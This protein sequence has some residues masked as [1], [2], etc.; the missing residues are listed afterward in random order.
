V[1]ALAALLTAGSGLSA[2]AAEKID[3]RYLLD[4]AV[5]VAAVGP[6]AVLTQPSL[7]M[8][9]VEV[10][11]AVGKKELGIDPLDVEQVLVQAVKP[12]G[13][14]PPGVG[15]VVHFSKPYQ[16]D[17][18]LPDLVAQTEAAELNGKPYRRA[19]QPMGLSMMM[20]DPQ[21]L[22]LGTGDMLSKMLTPQQGTNKLGRI[23]AAMPADHR[24][25]AL[26]DVASLRAPIGQLVGQLPPLPPPLEQFKQLPDLTDTLALRL[27]VDQKVR[28][29]IVFMAA[30]AEAAA[31]LQQLVEQG[32]TMG[33]QM[34]QAKMMQDAPKGDD[35]VDVAMRQYMMRVTDSLFESFQPKVQG[36][37]VTVTVETDMGM[38]SAGMMVGMLLP[39]VQAARGAA[40]RAQSSNNLKQIALAMHNYHDTYRHFPARATTNKEGKPLLSWRVQLLP[41]LE[42]AE[43]YKQFH[44]DEPWDSEHNKKL[45][46][47]MPAVY[48]SPGSEA[49]PG[50]ANYVV[51]VGK[52]TIFGGKEGVKFAQITDGT[53]NT[54]M[55]IEVDDKH[56]VIWTK[57]DDWE[58]NS[59]DPT[60]GLKQRPGNI[61]QLLFADGSVRSVAAEV[62]KNLA[63]RLLVMNDGQVVKL[64]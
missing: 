7:Q 28:Q 5:A 21:T 38:T 51:P 44:L 11:S 35:P 50:K 10:F 27:G 9:P 58:Y 61:V 32:L 63:D 53:S 22:L 45:I 24:V 46:A 40:R 49:E 29:E 55:A 19:K 47:Q 59:K 43:L 1:A 39:A 3:V 34:L 54:V 20:P 30:D 15:V 26:V 60:A 31:K 62:F 8:M 52:G 6:R 37:R 14:M 56:A 12:V 41:F 13:P 33:K 2:R 17:K 25:V 16:L 42:Q 57:P 18:I 36:T 48:R 4:D 23:L 64:P